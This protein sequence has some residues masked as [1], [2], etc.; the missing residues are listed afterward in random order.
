M[1]GEQHPAVM[2]ETETQNRGSNC[3]PEPLSH[4]VK[5]LHFCSS[6]CYTLLI[7][8][9]PSKLEERVQ[10]VF[11]FHFLLFL[12]GKDMLPKILMN[13]FLVFMM[14][15]TV[16]LFYSY[17]R[18]QMAA[19]DSGV[20]SLES[21]SLPRFLKCSWHLEHLQHMAPEGSEHTHI[22]FGLCPLQSP[23]FKVC[24]TLVQ[25][26]AAPSSFPDRQCQLVLLQGLAALLT[27]LF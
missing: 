24:P 27:P 10:F 1:P 21:C 25:S 2:S 19:R 3:H 23:N 6:E 4:Q 7:F 11:Q 16:Y 13:C 8:Y 18:I 22:L 12:E 5:A 14:E 15:K 26:K 20:E 17:I 9:F